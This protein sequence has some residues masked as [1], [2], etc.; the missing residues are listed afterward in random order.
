MLV[1]VRAG[2]DLN[3]MVGRVIIWSNIAPP[4]PVLAGAHLDVTASGGPM[5]FGETRGFTATAYD[6]TGR[7]LPQ[8]CFV[9]R[10]RNGSGQ[11]SGL[12]PSRDGRSYSIVFDQ[13]RDNGLTPPA[14]E[15]AFGDVS[16]EAEARIMGQAVVGRC[17]MTL[18][19]P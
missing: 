17:P 12:T 1:R 9:W 18:L 10:L 15:H 7:A 13:S 3:S 4:A 5:A 16:V 11:A 2:R 19:G 14:Q 6:G 8:C